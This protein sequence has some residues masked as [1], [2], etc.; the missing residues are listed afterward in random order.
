MAK[1]VDDAQ[2]WVKVGVTGFDEINKETALAQEK[3]KQ[4]K[5]GKN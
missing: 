5:G 4:M 3:I 2:E 1:Q